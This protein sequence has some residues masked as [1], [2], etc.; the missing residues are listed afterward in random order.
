MEVVN[1]SRCGGGTVMRQNYHQI[2][3]IPPHRKNWTFFRSNAEEKVCICAGSFRTI[4][5][6]AIFSPQ[7]KLANALTYEELLEQAAG[8]PDEPPADFDVNGVAES[9]SNFSSEN[10]LVILAGVA[11]VMV[12]FILSQVLQKP[13]RWGTMSAP[14]VY[15][16]L[17]NEDAQ[18]LD[19]RSSEDLKRT[20]SPDLRAFRKR[21][22]QLFYSGGK[23]APFLQRVCAK[24]KDPPNTTLYI[25][26]KFD[27]SSVVVAKLLSEN[28]FNAAYAIKGGAEGNNGWQG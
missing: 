19:I 22:V 15:S 18:L 4:T 26:D 23:D 7:L 11:L 1:A 16:A 25:L 27:G 9:V 5:S 13:K 21:A 6:A 14:N 17:Q 24:F 28:G 3:S 20:G 12:P 8:S 10:P 2:R